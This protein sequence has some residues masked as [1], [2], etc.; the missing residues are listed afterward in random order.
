M[1][2]IAWHILPSTPCTCERANPTSRD[3]FE[4]NYI[5]VSCLRAK[6]RRPKGQGPRE[7]RT[8]WPETEEVAPMAR[9]KIK[10]AFESASTAAPLTTP[11]PG[12][13]QI[14]NALD[15]SQQI[16]GRAADIT[17]I[18]TLKLDFKPSPA[19]PSVGV[20]LCSIATAWILG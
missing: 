17:S 11:K 20:N 5:E 16:T 15:K 14:D 3:E 9:I 2:T 8:K 18:P 10:C 13:I 4:A 6:G 19:Q 1:I 12:T 7:L